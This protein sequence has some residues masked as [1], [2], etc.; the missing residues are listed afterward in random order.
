MGEINTYTS[1]VA[2]SIEQQSATTSHISSNVANA[3]Q[4]TNKIVAMLDEVA[5]AAVT[6]RTSAEIVLNASQAV[7]SAVGNMR[8]EVESFLHDVAV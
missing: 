7:E 5:G 1:D 3:A 6:T 8:G 2:A 4:E